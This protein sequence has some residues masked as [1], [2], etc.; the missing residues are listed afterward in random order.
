M[1]PPT[2][3]A[4]PAGTRGTCCLSYRAA[5]STARQAAHISGDILSSPAAD[6]AGTT[7][8]QISIT[9]TDHHSDHKLAQVGETWEMSTSQDCVVIMGSQKLNI[10]LDENSGFRAL[11]GR[12]AVHSVSSLDNSALAVLKRAFIYASWTAAKCAAHLE[13]LVVCFCPLAPD[14][15]WG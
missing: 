10:S 12:T 15:G 1:P 3:L 4:L 5:L 6:I 14:D 9:V 7:L 8:V 2:V 11:A 13:A